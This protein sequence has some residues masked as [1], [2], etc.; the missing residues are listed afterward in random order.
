MGGSPRACAYPAMV[1]ASEISRRPVFT[2]QINDNLLVSYY[3]HN[4]NPLRPPPPSPLRLE[5]I[6][7]AINQYDASTRALRR[8]N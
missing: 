1:K 5:L 6:P 7:S 3:L 8:A 4:K 2:G